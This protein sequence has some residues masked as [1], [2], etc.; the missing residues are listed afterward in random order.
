MKHTTDIDMKNA[1]PVILKYICHKHSIRCP[2]LSEYVSNRDAILSE[3]EN[4]EEGKTAYLCAMNDGELNKKI[5]DKRF[6][7]FDEEMKTLQSQIPML[8]EYQNIKSSVPAEKK[9][10]WNGSALNRI[11]CMYENQILQSCISALNR[12]SIE[13]QVLMFD[14]VMIMGNHYNDADLLQHITTS[15]GEAY[16]ELDMVWCYKEHSQLIVVPDDFAR[17]RKR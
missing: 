8:P 12:R 17:R 14:G 4:K 11:L 9:F 6:R 7:A 2:M 13:I 16:P 15:V 5:K 10:N 3:F 1:H